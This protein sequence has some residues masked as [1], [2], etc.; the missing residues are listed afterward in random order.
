MNAEDKYQEYAE[1]MAITW[2]VHDRLVK[3][4]K[5]ENLRD[6]PNYRRAVEAEQK[7]YEAWQRSLQ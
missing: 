7:A 4:G 1:C 5:A 3:I 2:A 6:N